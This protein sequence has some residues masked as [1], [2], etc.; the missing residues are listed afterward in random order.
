MDRIRNVF[1]RL[2]IRIAICVYLDKNHETKL[3]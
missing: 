2:Q 3:N 1:R